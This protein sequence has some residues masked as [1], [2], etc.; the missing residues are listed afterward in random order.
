MQAIK[1]KQGQVLV[2][3]RQNPSKNQEQVDTCE[4]IS[5][6]DWQV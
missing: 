3:G 2:L 1:K 5:K 4:N 6:S